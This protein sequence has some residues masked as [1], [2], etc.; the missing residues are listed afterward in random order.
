MPTT[1]LYMLKTIRHKGQVVARWE[2]LIGD[3]SLRILRYE[4]MPLDGWLLMD[5]EVQGVD[6]WSGMAAPAIASFVQRYWDAQPAEPAD[7]ISQP[8]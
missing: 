6:A 8:S 3:E 7:L 4:P 5:S 2:L 1:T